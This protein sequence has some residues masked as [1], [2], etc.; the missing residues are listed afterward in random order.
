MVLA[1]IDLCV[2]VGQKALTGGN[3]VGEAV[4]T[5]P[6][7]VLEGEVLGLALAAEGVQLPLRPVQLP[8]EQEV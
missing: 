1:H 3:L 4:Q 5:V 6:Q 8:P 2:P 7:L